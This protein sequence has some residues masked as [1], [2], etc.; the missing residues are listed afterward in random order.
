MC[1]IH[2]YPREELLGIDYRQ[3]VDK[4][5]AKKAFEAFNQVYRTGEPGRLFDYEVIRKDGTKRQV[6]VF[7]SLR[8]RFVRQPE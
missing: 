2:G 5:N 4:E 1:K 7:P 8:K 6:E 3:F